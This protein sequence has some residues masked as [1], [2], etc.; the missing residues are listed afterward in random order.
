[1]VSK[2]DYTVLLTFALISI[3]SLCPKSNCPTWKSPRR[4]RTKRTKRKATR[5]W[6]WRCPITCRNIVPIH[7]DSNE[8]CISIPFMS[9]VNFRNMRRKRSIMSSIIIRL[10]Y[11]LDLVFIL[12]KW[13]VNS[14]VDCIILDNF[15]ILWIMLEFVQNGINIGAKFY[16][17]IMD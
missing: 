15:N 13:M 3:F 1:M 16:Q 6:W 9:T 7:M 11:N 5:W 12:N 2:S 14:K 10:F 17:S 4:R 8:G